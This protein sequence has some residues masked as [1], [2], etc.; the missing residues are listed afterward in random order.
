MVKSDFFPVTDSLYIVLL[1]IV[2]MEDFHKK[3]RLRRLCSILNVCS[4]TQKKYVPFSGF[5]YV[6]Q[7]DLEIKKS[8]EEKKGEKVN[9]YADIT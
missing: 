7:R 6:C 3:Y 9:D 2:R 1:V 4:Y 5:S 8:R